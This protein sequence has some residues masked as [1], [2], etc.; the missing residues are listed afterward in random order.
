MH[1]PTSAADGDEARPRAVVLWSLPLIALFVAWLWLAFA[2]GGSDPFDWL[3]GAL[4][5]GVVSVVVAA[6][7]AYPR[8][9][10]QL[11]MV[12]LVLAGLYALWVTASALW[13]DSA[14]TVWLEAEKTAFLLLVFALA[15]GYLSDSKARLIL[16]YLLMAAVFALLAGCIWRL[17]TIADID[18]LF[19]DGRL[20]FPTGYANGSAALFLIS[21]WPLVWLGA[22]PSE[23][24]PV[25]GAAL[26]LATGLLAM[27]VMTQSRGAIYSLAITLVIVF[28]VSPIR[29]RTLLYLIIPGLLLVYFFP[30]LNRY[31]LEGPSTV[32]GGVAA[33]TVLV[34]SIAAA[35]MG[36][37]VALLE[38]WIPASRRMKIIFGT[39]VLAGALAGIVYGAIVLTEDTE[40]PW[41]WLSKSWHQFTADEEP[42]LEQGT[43]SRLTVVGSSGAVA[44][45]KVAV[46]VFESKP[47]LG[48][49][50]GNF[51]YA[52]DRL[53]TDGA[54]APTEAHSLPLKILAETGVVGGILVGLTVVLALGGMLWGRFAA[55]WRRA[56]QRW[57]H[58][59]GR[60][61]RTVEEPLSSSARWGDDPSTYGWEM[62]LLSALAY[63]LIHAGFDSLWEITAIAV[64]AL[65]FLAAGV[66]AVDARVEMLW[67]R[68]HGWLRSRS[69][70]ERASSDNAGGSAPATATAEGLEQR[71]GAGLGQ[72][73]ATGIRNDVDSAPAGGA[74][75]PRRR[76]PDSASGEDGF[77][78]LRRSDQYSA[79]WRRRRRR[80]ARRQHM[81]ERLQPP[82]PLSRGFRTA[83][84]TV[85]ILVVVAAIPPYVSLHLQRSAVSL[86]ATDGLRSAAR[87]GHAAWLWPG[88]P[89][90]YSTQGDIYADA[91]GAARLM[92]AG[93]VLDNLALSLSAYE[94]AAD[95]EPAD[96]SPR[97]QAGVVALNMVLVRSS[98]PGTTGAPA[99]ID[100]TAQIASVPGLRDWS[101]LAVDEPPGLAGEE[102]KGS[103]WPP[104]GAPQT[105]HL[106]RTMTA[107]QL[108]ELALALL[109]E[110]QQ[111]CPGSPEV[112]EAMRL[113]QQLSD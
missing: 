36:M 98:Q 45:W 62:A 20:V 99:Q 95:V 44:I 89:S 79:K 13:A 42:P 48:V 83:L 110:A 96:W 64:P 97:Y 75:A 50:A 27:A 38:R 23:R 15:L 49:G 18:L 102:D 35:F 37:I 92:D 101:S 5:I 58:V 22:A 32:G 51:R 107:D 113:A 76:R 21:F 77:F 43:S 10:R 4:F 69:A 72:E 65:V 63:W 11:S 28:L 29:L 61:P 3:P 7:V 2:S 1:T 78:G 26:G 88:D 47:V 103:L 17:W 108:G 46:D 91:A 56:R 74:A 53:R 24:A 109:M 59:P 81:S 111:R 25:R 90:A 12:V 31:W 34:A 93:A 30:L 41:R 86:A 52:Y 104:Y 82:G 67:P 14:G 85:S 68:W 84:L 40:G 19:R 106:Y 16:R 71:A 100:Y 112:R 70:I 33:R 87:A 9:P 80:E 6:V 39:V 54:S 55:A 105:A 94:R 73:Q 60:E 57:L 8:R 66:S